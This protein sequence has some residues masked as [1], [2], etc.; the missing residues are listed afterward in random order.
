MS[1]NSFATSCFT[2]ADLAKNIKNLITR[3]TRNTIRNLLIFLRQNKVNKFERSKR[4]HCKLDLKLSAIVGKCMLNL[5]T[6]CPLSSVVES[7]IFSSFTLFL[8]LSEQVNHFISF[9]IPLGLFLF[10]SNEVW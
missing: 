7:P 1:I 6:I 5:S 9:L 3:Y 4:N 10:S 2:K 8:S